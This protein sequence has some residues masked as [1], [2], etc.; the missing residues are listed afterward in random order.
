MRRKENEL[1]SREKEVLKLIALPRKEIAKRLFI[2]LT[3]L[4]RHIT[5]IYKKLQTNDKAIAI[6]TAIE[7]G[8]I[9]NEDIV[10]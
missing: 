5:N 9:S 10:R 1:T 4:K 2:E 3:T 8:I 6:L 7:K